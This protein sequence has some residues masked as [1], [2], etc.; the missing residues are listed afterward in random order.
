MRRPAIVAVTAVAAVTVG[1]A[2]AVPATASA[3]KVPD[4]FGSHRTLSVSDLATKPLALQPDRQVSVIVR[5]SGTTV[6][7][8]KAAGL[9]KGRTLSRAQ[10]AKEIGRASCRER[11]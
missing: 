5:V 7:A 1:A 3:P 9:A 11:V 10:A 8:A 4:R 2:T 6:A